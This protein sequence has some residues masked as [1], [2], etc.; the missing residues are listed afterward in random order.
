MQD[1]TRNVYEKNGGIPRLVPAFVT[2]GRSSITRFMNGR[3]SAGEYYV[4]AP[5]ASRDVR[6]ENHSEF[7]PL[8]MLKHFSNH[9]GVPQAEKGGC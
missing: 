4:G 6:V 9:P 8:V 3:L 7:E 5:A 1:K 2:C